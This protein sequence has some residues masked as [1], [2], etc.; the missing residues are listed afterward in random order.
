MKKDIATNLHVILLAV[1]GLL[2]CLPLTFSAAELRVVA[3]GS[4][5]D[6]V[7]P[8]AEE[9]A[10]AASEAAVQDVAVANDEDP[11]SRTDFAYLG[12]A[13]TEVSVTLS[14]QSD[15]NAGVGLVA[16]FVAPESPAAKA[17]LQKNDVLVEFEE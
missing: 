2:I 12:I 4:T 6:P 7:H 9:P 15:L 3:T 11:A 10:R 5:A 8:D 17:G 16:T 1:A 13:T 14:A